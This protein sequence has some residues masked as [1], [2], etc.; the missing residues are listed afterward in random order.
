[1]QAVV[2]DVGLM[3]ADLMEMDWVAESLVVVETP[4]AKGMSEEMASLEESYSLFRPLAI[5][6]SQPTLL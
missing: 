4:R 2:A 1:M 3:V 6:E 5:L